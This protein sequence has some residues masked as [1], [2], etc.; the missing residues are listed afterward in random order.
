MMPRRLAR[1]LLGL[2]LTAWCTAAALAEVSV[3]KDPAGGCVC[4][5]A[6]VV[7]MSIVRASLES[8]ARIIGR[9]S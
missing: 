3:L 1:S 8:M 9:H 6:R 5:G 2:G 7:V 4:G